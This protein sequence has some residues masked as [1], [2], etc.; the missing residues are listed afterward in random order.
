MNDIKIS[1]NFK[2]SE[3]ESRDTKEVKITKELID[4]LEILRYKLGSQPLIINSGY[5]TPEH[6][7]AVGGAP[8]SKHM[9]GIAADV[10]KV[11]DYTIDEM[12]EIAEEI[13]FTGIGKYNTFIHV[14][15][16]PYNARWDL[17]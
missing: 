12:A 3:F 11:K 6:N 13:G 5:R 14:D 1:Q 16:R 9:E 8:E 15:C 17:R 2:L 4:R 7:K 10:K